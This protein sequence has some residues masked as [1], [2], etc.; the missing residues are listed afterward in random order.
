[1]EEI[2]KVHIN[3]VV[4]W[5]D[6]FFI[7]KDDEDK[8]YKGNAI[9][10]PAGDVQLLGT[11]KT[12]PKYGPT[13]VVKHV[14]YENE[15]QVIK[16]LLASGFIE[17][18]R[19][20]KAEAVVDR[21]GKDLF[22]LLDAALDAPEAM[23]KYKGDIAV[24]DTILMK[25]PGIGPVVLK[26]M[27][28]SWQLHRSEVNVAI[29][30]IRA[31]LT[32]TQYK[33]AIQQLMASDL[34]EAILHNPYS[35]TVVRGIDWETV[36]AIAQL[37]WD[38]KDKI[39]HD[40]PNRLAAAVREILRRGKNEGHMCMNFMPAIEQAHALAEE[41]MIWIKIQDD[42][43]KHGL[44]TLGMAE[45]HLP[46]KIAL[47][48]LY[49]IEKGTAEM[50]ASL[51]KAPGKP[52]DA[53]QIDIAKYAPFKLGMA[54]LEAVGM[55]LENKICIVTG[56]PGTGKTAAVLAT[57][58]N[59]FEANHMQVTL[60][61]PT[62]KA[63]IRMEEATKHTAG[64]LHRKFGLMAA[65]THQLDTPVLVI[66]E[67]S[68]VSADLF[69][70]VLNLIPM[71]A[72]IIMIGDSD[73]LP[74]V[75]PGE[76]LYQM[77]KAKVPFT[78]LDFIFRQ[79]EGSG[80][81]NA[82][83]D[84]NKGIAPKSAPEDGY[85]TVSIPEDQIPERITKAV[86]WLKSKDIAWSDTQILTPVNNGPAGRIELNNFL[87][88][89]YNP[90]DNPMKGFPF[91]VDDKVIHT[92]NNYDL[93]VMNGEVGIVMDIAPEGRKNIM[94]G[95]GLSV[96]WDEG[97]KF[98]WVKYPM[99]DE[100]VA[101]DRDDLADLQ[102]AY[103]ITIHKSQGSE[104]DGVVLVLPNTSNM[105][106][107]RQL[108]YTGITRA[109]KYCAVIAGQGAMQKY[110]NGSNRVLRQSMLAELLTMSMGGINEG[111]QIHAPSMVPA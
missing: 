40:D 17:G 59:V 48:S 61:A 39:T 103:A 15:V 29:I 67:F 66:D 36:D 108:P 88:D 100:L 10:P 104:F 84:V 94:L 58:M 5:R 4:F 55:A 50:L 44:V 28:E 46:Q 75:G 111:N 33:N 62:G 65:E 73:Q 101:Y 83:A 109:A 53:S 78:R 22:M 82:A 106:Y 54:Q 92:R 49:D 20:G 102:L 38:G 105:F 97:L 90:G 47:R 60:C 35:L 63:A 86:D 45:N 27:K 32:G 37:E 69:Y 42:L 2:L 3:K 85:A 72:R 9:F 1:M 24:P 25:T 18:I 95:D 6:N 21:F 81:V 7:A 71:G 12:D 80:I 91:R 26:W 11:W 64:T 23:I 57:I 93:G 89:K 68:M 14:F 70:D 107:L 56:G 87:Q 76:P 16:M 19:E 79:R 52:F 43:E 96:N 31:G 98:V 74:P 51:M 13:F 77:L 8:S 99:H 110:V 41:R 34:I 30:G